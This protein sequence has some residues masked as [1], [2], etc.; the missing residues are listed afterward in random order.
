MKEKFI[1]YF[2]YKW[3]NDKNQALLEDVDKEIMAQLPEEVQEKIYTTYL[4]GN[5]LLQFQRFILVR[6]FNTS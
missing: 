4:Y 6:N 1:T 2:E 5:F 3:E